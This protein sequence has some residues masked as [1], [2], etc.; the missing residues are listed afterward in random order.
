MSKENNMI[1]RTISDF[2]QN[3]DENIYRVSV[4]DNEK[5]KNIRVYGSVFNVKSKL[6]HEWVYE[7]GESR[8]FYEIIDSKAF[9]NVL[10]NKKLDVVLSVNHSFR[11]LLGRTLSGT[12]VLSTD[13]K[14]LFGDCELPAT[15]RGNEVYV[16]AKRGDYYE[17]S[18]NYQSKP[19]TDKWEVQDDGTYIKTVM[20]IDRLYD[21]TVA[22]WHGAYA[23][24][25]IIITE[26]TEK[27]EDNNYLIELELDKDKLRF[28][29][30]NNKNNLN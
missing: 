8:T 1:C 20:E 10:K 6:I 16:M 5:T 27:I 4:S 15:E 23:G 9:D 18:F 30:L 2:I 14:G 11:E 3:E 7:F 28:L 29:S 13:E 12:L 25:D 21:I 22:T 17:S 24:T 26:R 19:G